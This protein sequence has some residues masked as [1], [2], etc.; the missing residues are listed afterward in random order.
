[1]VAVFYDKKNKTEVRSDQLMPIKFVETTL[2]V[3]AEEI[4]SGRWAGNKKQPAYLTTKTLATIGYK[5]KDCPK[6]CNWNKYLN[7]SD[8]VFLRLDAK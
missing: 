4:E 6:A 7:E 8:L 5:S 1:M 3:D 2:V